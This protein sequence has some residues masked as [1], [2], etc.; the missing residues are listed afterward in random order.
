MGPP[1]AEPVSVSLDITSSVSSVENMIGLYKIDQVANIILDSSHLLSSLA[2]RPDHPLTLLSRATPRITMFG[3]SSR[4]GSKTH[5]SVGEDLARVLPDDGIPWYKKSYLLYLNYLSV[6]L[7]LLAA[8]TG[9]DGSMM[10]GLQALPQWA[11]F[12]DHP[13][14]AWLGFINAIQFISSAVAYPVTAYFANRWG[15]KKGIFIGYFFI[16]LGALLQTFAP[17]GTAFILSRMFVGQPSAWW[18]GL[19]PLLITELAYP[20]NRSFLTTLFNCGYYVGSILSA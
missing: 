10:N 12:M 17:N 5:A 8:A 7:G 15:R 2:G 11:E 1:H 4:S 6:S 16:F 14:G 9:Y 20:T 3:K 18:G 13:T 19:A